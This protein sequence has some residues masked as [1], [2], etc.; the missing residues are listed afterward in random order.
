MYL[1][2]VGAVYGRDPIM[3]T[4]DMAEVLCKEFRDLDREHMFVVNLDAQNRPISYHTVGLGG[5][6]A[7]NFPIGNVFKTAIIQNAVSI[8]LCHNHPSGTLRPSDEDLKATKQCVKVGNLI[9][10]KVLDHIILTP[11]NYRSLRETNCELF[12]D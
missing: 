12:Y 4:T 7:V 8:V 10:I 5:T 6:H 9:G 2:E 11:D 3:N 1:K